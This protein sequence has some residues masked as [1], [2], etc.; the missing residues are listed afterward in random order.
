MASRRYEFKDA[1]ALAARATGAPGKR[2]FYILAGESG[3]V[4]RLLVEKEQLMLLSEAIDRLLAEF[5]WKAS[6]S[7]RQDLSA[8]DS[9][10]DGE[11]RVGRLALAADEEGRRIGLFAF[12]RDSTEHSPP[13]VRCWATLDKMHAFARQI[14]EVCAAGRPLCP[15]CDS[16]IDPEGHVCP[17]TNGHRAGLL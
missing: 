8:D 11:I 9:A 3:A 4:V 12:A 16:P 6:G 17:K 15:L 14:D 1:E 7:G 13:T 2:T 5:S 10:A